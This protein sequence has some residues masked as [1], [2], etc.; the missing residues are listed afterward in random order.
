[1]VRLVVLSQRVWSMVP[2]LAKAAVIA[3]VALMALAGATQAVEQHPF[4]WR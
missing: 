1:M 3:L 4:R 2:L